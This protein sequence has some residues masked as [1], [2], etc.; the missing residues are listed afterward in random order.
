VSV[1][2]AVSAGCAAVIAVCFAIAL[3]ELLNG[4]ARTLR[5]DATLLLPAVVNVAVETAALIAGIVL[6]PFG[7][8]ALRPARGPFRV[9]NGS[10]ERPPVVLVP[11]WPLGAL[12]LAVLRRRLRRDGWP[13]VIVTSLPLRG[14]LIAAARALA[15]AVDAA[16]GGDQTAPVMLIAHGTGGVV[17]RAYLRWLGGLGR[18]TK[19][20]TLATPHQGSKLYAL[21]LGGLPRDLRPESDA[22]AELAVDDP[23]PAA[24]DC[25]AIYAS[26]DVTVVPSRLAYYAGA[27]NIEV[28]GAGHFTMPWS[29]RVYELLRENLEYV[30]TRGAPSVTGSGPPP[31]A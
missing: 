26:F 8:L 16:C 6:L 14:D 27:G 21:A 9:S 19:L 29:R 24:I 23:L 18:T 17:C 28:E 7:W 13:D 1:L 12:S 30:A 22:L 2:I 25:T 4:E 31:A 10:R 5:L 20:V 11:T 15:S 3:Y